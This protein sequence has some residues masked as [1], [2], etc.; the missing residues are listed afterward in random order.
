MKMDKAI[1]L[2]AAALVFGW[3][4]GATDDPAKIGFVD[5]EQCLATTDSGKSAREE[6]E[7]KG[8]D[9]QQRLAPIVEQL[10]ALQKEQLAKKFVMSEEAARSMQLDIIELQNR[11]ETKVKEE[12]GQLK[13]DQQRVLGPLLEKLQTVINEVG[14]ENNFSAILRVDAPGLVY[15]REALDITDLVIKTFD[16]KG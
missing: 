4:I 6:L 10:D 11:Y 13:I 15:K 7:R 1:L 5:M 8:R 2:V 16:R 14:R 9:A 12:E 3:G